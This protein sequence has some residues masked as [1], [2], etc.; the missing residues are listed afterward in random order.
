MDK[1]GKLFGKISIVDLT[2]LLLILVVGIGTIYRF[3]ASAAQVDE[4]HTNI[5]F[6]VRIEGVR[7]FT[8]YYYHGGLPV[9]DRSTGQFIGTIAGVHVEPHYVLTTLNDGSIIMA[10]MPD[11]YITIYLTIAAAGRETDG[12]I[13]AEGTFEVAVNSTLNLRTRYVQVSGLIYDIAIR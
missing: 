8:L 7:D 4:A 10:R 6:T 3:S 11:N 5:E 12:A 9:H 2:V 13:F 1:N